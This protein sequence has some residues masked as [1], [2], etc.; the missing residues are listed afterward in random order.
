MK[1]I[2]FRSLHNLSCACLSPFNCILL[3]LV[4][5]ARHFIVWGVGVVIGSDGGVVVG[6]VA[7]GKN[8][9]VIK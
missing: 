4:T 6:V 2:S 1:T 5:V 8:C 9:V 3:Q 7:G